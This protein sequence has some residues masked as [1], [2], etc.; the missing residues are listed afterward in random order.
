M[1]TA[2]PTKSGCDAGKNLVDDRIVRQGQVH[3]FG[4][5]HRVRRRRRDLCPVRF[6]GS[7]LRCGPVP[8]GHRVA[9][10]QHALDHP[11]AEQPCPNERHV[12]HRI[13]PLQ[14]TPVRRLLHRHVAKALAA[15]GAFAGL[16]ACI[17]AVLLGGLSLTLRAEQQT[18]LRWAGD[19]EGGAP[20]VEADPVTI[21][22]RSSASTSK[23]PSCLRAASAAH[24]NSSTS[25]FTSIDQS[26]AR[27]D[28]DI[29]LSGIEDTPARRAT[30]AVTIP[31]TSSAKC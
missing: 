17:G 3:V 26:I 25:T 14:S 7:R 2:S 16:T 28:A 6:K 30:L 29:G 31:T 15:A 1:T 13:L 21:P 8:D 12:R 22:D 27:G 18:V 4:R 19:P 11:A 10:S 23:S 20:F 9:A 24:R 5:R